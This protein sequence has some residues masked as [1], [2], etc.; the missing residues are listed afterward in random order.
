MS[1]K[2][3][4]FAALVAVASLLIANMQPSNSVDAQFEQFKVTHKKNYEN[5]AEETYRKSV[6]LMNLAKIAAHNADKTQTHTLGVTQF[7]DLTQEEFVSMHLTLKVNEKYSS[8]EHGRTPTERVG[9]DVDWVAA[10]KVSAV[11]NQGNCG[12]CWA[13]SANAAIESALLIA[14]RTENLSEQQ[15]VDCS[16][17]YGNQGCSGGW[18]DSAFDYVVDHGL[19][20]T[21]KYPYVAR[22]QACAVDGGSIKISGYVD[23]KGCN[24][25]ENAL[26]SRPISVAVDASVWSQYRGGV[27]TG[28]GTSVNHGV[29]LV[30]ATD[31][32][33]R[34]KNSWGASWGESGF[35]RIG[36]GN[37]CAVCSYPSYPTL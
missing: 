35:I 16:R 11:K 31:A 5:V 34:I 20:T 3:L 19:T 29:L 15:L 8:V 37:T 24:D 9:G 14:G 4:A 12:S 1:T 21:D 27:L 30:G 28:C 10:G 32:S 6:F 2:I 13:F 18:M 26:S 22:N 7:S 23:V 36:K 25:L 17:A 33:W